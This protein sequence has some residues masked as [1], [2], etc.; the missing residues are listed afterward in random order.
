M[1]WFMFKF[2]FIGVVLMGLCF[3][4]V[5]YFIVYKSVEVY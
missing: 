2:M 4:I 1:F 5:F 3:V